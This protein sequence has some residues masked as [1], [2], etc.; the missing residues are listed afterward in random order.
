MVPT[1][2]NFWSISREK[3]L[4]YQQKHALRKKFVRTLLFSNGFF[5]P[6][7]NRKML[8]RKRTSFLDGVCVNYEQLFHPVQ[9][10]AC[11][12]CHCSSRDK[13][14]LP[15]V[16]GLLSYSD[17][18]QYLWGIN[19]FGNGT[20]QNSTC[21]HQSGS[22]RIPFSYHYILFTSDKMFLLWNQSFH[23]LAI[24]AFQTTVNASFL[25][26]VFWSHK[27]EMETSQFWF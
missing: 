15:E 11:R 1:N 17:Q 25:G 20:R 16:T 27:Y 9:C 13:L 4:E 2:L 6:G 26:E 14:V 24:P 12:I 22:L 23:C 3:S 7:Y 19:C 21:L 8:M 18:P 10:T 5:S